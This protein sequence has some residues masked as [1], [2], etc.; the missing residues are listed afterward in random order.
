LRRFPPPPPRSPGEPRLL[1]AKE[2]AVF[3]NLATGSIYRH[4]RAGVLHS[5]VYRIG[6]RTLRFDRLK[7]LEDLRAHDPEK[8]PE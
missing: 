4:V 6:P 8:F 3:L 1:A 2:L 7:S 5:G